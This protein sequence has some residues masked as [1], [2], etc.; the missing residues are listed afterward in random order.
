[1]DGKRY[2]ARAGDVLWT[3][4][5]CVHAFAN[6]G[7]EPVRWLETF[8]PQP[9]SENV[10][11]FMAEWET[12]RQGTGGSSIMSAESHAPVHWR[13]VPR[14]HSRRPRDLDLRRARQGRDD[15]SGV[16]EHGADDRAAVR[17]AARSSRKDVLTTPTDTG[18]GGYHP[19]LLSRPREMPR[20]WS[21]AR[22]AIAEWARV[23][24]GWIGRSPDYKAAFLATLGAN[25]DLLRA[26]RRQRAALVQEGPGGSVV[27][28]PRDRESAGRSRQAARRGQGRV[29]ARRGGDRRRPD[30]ERR[31]GGGDDV[32]A[33]ALQLHREQR[34]AA[35]QDEAV[36][37]RLHRA[38]RLAG[39]EAVLPAVVRDDGCGDGHARSTTR[40]RAGWTRTTRSSSS[41]RCSCRG[42]TC[43]RTAT[44]TR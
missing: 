14:E 22:D 24:Y 26:V 39:R 18:S 19:P 43:S 9:P 10:F 44:S 27:R 16:P 17:R 15:A 11:R 4:V 42:R 41:T 37:V 1:M 21:A 8:S 30:R 40:S 36:R 31:E 28:Q 5:G 20:S 2:L 6:K 33:D 7:R 35:D 29:H 38:D 3:G 32:D 25:S 34:R 23:T 13:R 12:A